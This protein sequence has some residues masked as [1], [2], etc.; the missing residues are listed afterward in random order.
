MHQ[1]AGQTLQRQERPGEHRQRQPTD[2]V[3][4][5]NAIA[6]EKNPVT[7][8]STVVARK[9][10]VDPANLFEPNIPART[11]RPVRIPTRLMIT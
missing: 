7:L 3:G 4:R 2:D 11:M 5:Q 1:V 10:A 6:R 8:V 9:R